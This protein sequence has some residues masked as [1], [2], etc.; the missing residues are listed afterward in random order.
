MRTT[1]QG[2]KGELAVCVAPASHEA[3]TLRAAGRGKVR[4]LTRESPSCSVSD[5]LKWLPL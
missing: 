2:P 4:P 1:R 5:D 3:C